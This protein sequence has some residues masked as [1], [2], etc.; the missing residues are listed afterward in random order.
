VCLLP[1]D[2]TMHHEAEIPRAPK[3]VVFFSGN[4]ATPEVD[5][6][7]NTSKRKW[8]TMGAIYW[9]SRGRGQWQ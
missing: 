2:M 4:A 1:H 5:H 9:Y 6:K 3:F 8:G 7:S